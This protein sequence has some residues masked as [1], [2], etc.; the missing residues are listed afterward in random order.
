[1]G[2][3]K[4]KQTLLEN[5]QEDMLKQFREVIGDVKE[6]KSQLESSSSESFPSL[7][8]PQNL[9]QHQNA[10][11]RSNQFREHEPWTVAGGAEQISEKLRN[12]ISHARRTVGLSR[13]GEDD[14][15]RTR[16]EQYG[17]AKTEAEERMLAVQEFFIYEMKFRR[18]VLDTMEIEEIFVPANN[19]LKY[20][21]VTFKYGSSIRKVYERTKYMRKESRINNFFPVEFEDRHS[22]LKEVEKNLREEDRSYQTRIKMGLNDLEFSKKIRGSGR[23]ERVPLPQGLAKIDLSR[24]G[25][26]ADQRY[27]PEDRA[28]GS[29][30][31]APGRPGQDRGE[32]RG[33]ESGSSP[34]GQNHP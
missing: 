10:Q 11:P 33:R 22:D 31:P 29:V 13:I 12:V 15:I 4:E 3:I 25:A 30:S 14:L 24:S 26:E 5:V 17:G 6:I 2:P 9:P 7:P 16:Q 28:G 27:P 21:F 18:E 20:L 23:W 1:M 32:K 34:A 19:D 8:N